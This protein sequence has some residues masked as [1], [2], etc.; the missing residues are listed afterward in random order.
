MADLH[1]HCLISLCTEPLGT[2]LCICA[3]FSPHFTNYLCNNIHSNCIFQHMFIFNIYFFIL[4]NNTFTYLF[5]FLNLSFVVVFSPT[6]PGQWLP[7]CR[8]GQRW[9]TGP[10]CRRKALFPPHPDL[11]PGR[12]PAHRPTRGDITLSSF[13]PTMNHSTQTCCSLVRAEWD[14]SNGK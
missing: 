8:C 12:T 11:D 6:Q 2:P 4:K 5:F 3:V 14:N 10:S 1:A 13:A 7:P 9:T